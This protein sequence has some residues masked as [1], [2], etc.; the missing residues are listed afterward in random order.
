MTHG[1][2]GGGMLIL[3]NNNGINQSDILDSIIGLTMS[4]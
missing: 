3:K 4:N 1:G 2:E